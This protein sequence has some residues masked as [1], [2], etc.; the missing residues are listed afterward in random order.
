MS[1][2]PSAT[3]AAAQP[4]NAQTIIF[5]VIL[6]FV[7]AT[8]LSLLASAL[9]EP[10]QKA[11][12]LYRSKQMLVAARILHPTGGYLQIENDK[13]EYVPAK[14]EANGRLVPGTKEDIATDDQLLK[15]YQTRFTPFLVD[16]QGKRYTFEETKIDRQE[17]LVENHKAGFSQLPYKLAYEIRPNPN[18]KGDNAQTPAA[19]YIV[20]V[21]GFGLWDAIYGYLAI[22]PDANH[23]IGISWYEHKETPGLGANISEA[24]WQ[25]LFPGRVIFQEGADGNTN[26]QTGPVGI[27][28]VRGK[29]AE[30]YGDSPKAKSAV[31]GMAGATLT[32]NGVTEAYQRVLSAYRPFLIAVHDQGQVDAK[33]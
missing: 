17:Y 19:G 24:D 14:V 31:D 7:C 4:S 16:D 9:A 6:S 20:P 15:V 23:V 25:S 10:Q 12:D 11:R 5:M 2:Q 22:A 1:A 21:N 28:V 32:G 3:G 26:W 33:K 29:V 18:G 30:V 13:G 27:T 8:I